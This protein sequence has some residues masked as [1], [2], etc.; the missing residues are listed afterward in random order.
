MTWGLQVDFWEL[1]IKLW[2]DHGEWAYW[3]E[4]T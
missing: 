4:T 3:G 1:E 2:Q